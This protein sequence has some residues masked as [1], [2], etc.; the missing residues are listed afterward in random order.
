[1]PLPDL[2]P[3]PHEGMPLEATLQ[4]LVEA[5]EARHLSLAIY[6]FAEVAPGQSL[7]QCVQQLV[8]QGDC[9]GPHVEVRGGRQSWANHKNTQGII[10]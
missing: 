6:Q 9:P 1:M 5:C 7:Q 3:A 2:L 10:I 4:Q 8:Q